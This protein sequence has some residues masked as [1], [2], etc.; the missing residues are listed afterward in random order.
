[1]TEITKT[2][3]KNKTIKKHK[4]NA[5]GKYKI[6][7]TKLLKFTDTETG[8]LT[9]KKVGA[10]GVDTMMTMR[11]IKDLNNMMNEKNADKKLKFY[12]RSFGIM[13]LPFVLKPYE[14]EFLEEKQIDDYIKGTVQDTTKFNEIFTVEIGYTKIN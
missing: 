4:K 6:E 2:N 9:V 1:M 8:V 5:D 12:I 7:R 13:P 3:F 14:H 11:D 10:D